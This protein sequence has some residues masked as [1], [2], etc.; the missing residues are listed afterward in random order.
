VACASTSV[1]IAV[2]NYENSAGAIVTLAEEWNGTAW[3]IQKTPKLKGALNSFPVLS[4]V[5]CSSTSACTAVGSYY[6]NYGTVKVTLAEAWNGI[7]WTIQKTPTPKGA[8]NS[9]LYG[10]ACQSTSVCIAVGTY[11]NGS[12]V[13]VTLAEAWNGIAWTIQKTPEPK[14]ACCSALYGVA[15][16]S[17]NACIAVGTSTNNSLAEAWNGIAWTIQKTPTPKGAGTTLSS[18]A[19]SSTSACTAVGYYGNDSGT[20]TLVAEAWSGTTWTIQ[21]TPKP[22]GV[23]DS[24]LYGVACPSTSACTAVGWYYHTKGS[25]ADDTLA[26]AW[27]GTASTPNPH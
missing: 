14:G 16:Q 4:A 23:Y 18:V 11:D 8:L 1:C 21:N 15:C 10:V 25:G 5:A 7:A 2:G 17:A 26:E 24:Y 6:T 3:T 13:G 22:N 20:S 12:D 27:N 9:Y 19:C